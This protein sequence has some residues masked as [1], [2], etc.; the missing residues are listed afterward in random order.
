MLARLAPALLVL[1][2]AS[3][4]RAAAQESAPE[5]AAPE[6][7]QR[8]WD[9]V[10]AKMARRSWMP[11]EQAWLELLRAHA[12]QAYVTPHVE[13]IRNALRKCAFWRVTKEPDPRS[14]VKGK[15]RSYSVTS[16]QIEI[17]YTRETLG[18][19]ELVSKHEPVEVEISSPAMGILPKPRVYMHPL[20]FRGPYT[21][22]L[23]GT[24]E[25][26]VNVSL[27]VA[28]DGQKGYQVQIGGLFEGPI[29]S[30]N[31]SHA[32][33][34]LGA[35][36]PELLEK[37]PSVGPS[38]VKKGKSPAQTEIEAQVKVDTR[39][40]TLTY[41]G[42]R[43]VSVLNE[44]K[45]LGK[46]GLGV[47][48]NFG[49]LRLKG[50]VEP[51][52]IDG[53]QD[54]A[55]QSAREAFDATWTDPPELEPWKDARPTVTASARRAEI[56][57]SIPFQIPVTAEQQKR[58]DGANRLRSQG[59]SALARDSLAAL[60]PEDLPP[61]ARALLLALCELELDHV[62]PCLLHLEELSALQ[63][64]PLGLRYLR[65][66]LLARV[67]RLPEAIEL[68]RTIVA[69]DDEPLAHLELTQDLLLAGR[70]EEARDALERGL[71]GEAPLAELTEMRVKLAKA[72]LGPEWSKT[73]RQASKRF[74]V[75]SDLD[76]DVS[77]LAVRELDAAWKELVDW[78]GPV[79]DPAAPTRAYLFSGRASY[80]GYIR[81]IAFDSPENTLGIY[82]TLLDQIAVW[83]SADRDLLLR[84]LWHE[85]A[86]HYVDLAL[87]DAP[88][89]L[90]EGLAEYV[91]SSRLGTRKVRRGAMN[92]QALPT[93]RRQ[94]A[95]L[96]PLPE[97]LRLEHGPFM[98]KGELHYP[99][100][101]AVFHY[102]SSDDPTA[103]AF[104]AR[105]WQALAQPRD[106]D[107]A[108]ESALAGVDLA[109][110]AAGF[111]AHLDGLLG[112]P[113]GR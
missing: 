111:E 10:Q 82:S 76:T 9:D 43:V 72:T 108:L 83:N 22:T 41:D 74:E 31:Y 88:T 67:E 77:R 107:S 66:Q 5:T 90:H 17:E 91:A 48:G 73:F 104:L 54:A 60:G 36:E 70:L 85:C 34:R 46:W 15:L 23:E 42:K 86:H 38:K 69:E 26:L 92:D 32:I 102:L 21:F 29:S 97:F 101:W 65:A 57:D 84:T 12:G 94:R 8:A 103:S 110:L 71:A 105:L 16:G 95:Q 24:A 47:T 78:F 62:D 98:A 1:T 11:A 55:V 44:D 87:G 35:G 20:T 2:G 64:L 58:I 61:A 81:G 33:L 80:E 79:P 39:T 25:E 30:R 89:W 37:V 113:E 51:S 18:D 93:L 45:V 56:L 40:I 106:A 63:P 59:K 96:T 112:E 27:F 7:F 100:A 53:V 14:A 99:Q 49:T 109:A 50:T 28:L 52:W 13:E 3:G 4:P 19:L 6:E 68:L 75:G